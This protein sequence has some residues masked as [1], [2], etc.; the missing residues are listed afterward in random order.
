MRA[1][2]HHAIAITGPEARNVR[3]GFAPHF[4]PNRL[5]LG[6]TSTGSLPLLKDKTLPTTT[7]FVCVENTCQL[8]VHSVEA[9][10]LQIP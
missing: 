2:P 5:F 10:V 6:H 3:M 9:A 4:L 8:P 7:I 1:F